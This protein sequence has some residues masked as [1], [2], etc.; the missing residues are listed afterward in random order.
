MGDD[1]DGG[2][3]SP[4]AIKLVRREALVHLAG[5]CQA[6]IFTLV[7]AATY[8]ARYWSGR[9]MTVSAPRLSTTLIA[10]ED[11][12]ADVDLGLHLGKTYSHRRP[13]E[14][15]D[16]RTQGPHI[17]TVIEDASEQ[18]AFMSGIS[19]VLFGFSSLEVSALK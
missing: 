15:R 19:T 1:L 7:R 13:R 5:Q 16:S 17:S 2:I 9:K 18:P 14:R 8:F 6:M 4:V 10:L 11:V 12:Q 3:F